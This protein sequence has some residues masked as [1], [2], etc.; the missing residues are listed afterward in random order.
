MVTLPL[1]VLTFKFVTF[2]D[3][4]IDICFS[5]HLLLFNYICN[6][7]Y[8]PLR[9]VVGGIQGLEKEDH[10]IDHLRFRVDL[11]LIIR[12]FIFITVHEM[13]WTLNERNNK[14]FKNCMRKRYYSLAK[15]VLAWCR[16]HLST[17]DFNFVSCLLFSPSLFN[18]PIYLSYSWQNINLSQIVF[19]KSV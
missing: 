19:T 10:Y 9:R 1:K 14:H 2:T 7:I 5:F 3:N 4:N 18:F 11:L 16:H 6:H 17:A 13:N 12:C 8:I 15:I